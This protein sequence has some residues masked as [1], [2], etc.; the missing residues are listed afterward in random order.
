MIDTDNSV[1]TNQISLLYVDD[2]EVLLHLGKRFLERMGEFSVDIV[3][4]AGEVLLPGFLQKYD[5]IISDYQM[6]VIDGIEFLK[7]IREH[8]PFADLKFRFLN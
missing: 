2:E 3:Q 7:A 5:A 6:P 1:S 4:S 8:S